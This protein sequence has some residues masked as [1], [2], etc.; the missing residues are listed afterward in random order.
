MPEEQEKNVAHD[1]DV[2]GNE[3]ADGT[4]KYYLEE[5]AINSAFTAWLGAKRGDFIRRPMLGGLLD[6]LLFKGLNQRTGSQIAFTIQNAIANEFIPEITLV[7]LSVT[8]DYENRLWKIDIKYKNPFSNQVES[9]A[10]Y[11]KDLSSKESFDYVSIEYIGNNLYAF[12]ETKLPSM[13]NELIVYNEDREKWIWGQYE[14]TNFD[15]DDP[16][17]NDILTLVNGS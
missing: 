15:S 16:R 8:P 13:G 6:T 17:Y 14:L 11:T 10:I 4:P 1:I 5:E 7:D 12:C 2:F 9:I 3:N